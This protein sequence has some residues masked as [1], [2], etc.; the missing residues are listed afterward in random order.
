MIRNASRAPFVPTALAL[1]IS[2]AALACTEAPTLIPGGE[3][4]PAPGAGPT[5]GLVPF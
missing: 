2:F 3:T 5:G 4:P 1:A